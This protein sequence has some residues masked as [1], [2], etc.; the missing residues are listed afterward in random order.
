MMYSMSVLER[1]YWIFIGLLGKFL[2]W[3]LGVSAQKKYLGEKPYIKLRQRGKPVIF[4]LW[5][6]RILFAAYFFRRR[7]INT[8]VSPSRDGEI[9]AQILSRWG[10]R[11]LRGSGSHSVVEE[12]KKMKNLM[13]EGEELIIVA[14]GPKGPARKMKPGALKLAQET[15]AYLVPFAFSAKK[16]KLLKSWDRFL[17]FYPFTKLVAAYGEPLRIKTDLDAQEFE[18]ERIRIQ[19]YLCNLEEQTDKIFNPF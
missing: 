6:G 8:L 1:V 12:W 15:G 19:N 4:I 7:N 14:D 16:K 11:L 17:F 18:R 9:I 2:V 3:F 13:A 5:H 10:Y